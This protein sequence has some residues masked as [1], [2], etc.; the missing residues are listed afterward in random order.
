MREI[1]LQKAQEKLS[2]LV[3]DALKSKPTIITRDG[4]KS[5]VILSYDDYQ[6]LPGVR[7]SAEAGVMHE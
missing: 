7:L 1:E 5:A 6:N 4:E 2:A 3:K